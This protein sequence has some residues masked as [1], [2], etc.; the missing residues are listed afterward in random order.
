MDDVVGFIDHLDGL[1]HVVMSGEL[2]VSSAAAAA[3][4]LDQARTASPNVIIDM[5]NVTFF[6]SSG[7]HVLMHL[8]R[9]VSRVGGKVTV[10]NPPMNVRRV[11]KLAAVDHLIDVETQKA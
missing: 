6:D 3:A 8:W 10:Q 1:V 4:L 11:F 5:S 2:D 9:D 7:L